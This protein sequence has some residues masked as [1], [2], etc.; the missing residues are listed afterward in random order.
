MAR[1]ILSG[2]HWLMFGDIVA[3]E[4]P[5][6]TDSRAERRS[7]PAQLEEAEAE[8]GACA[9]CATPQFGSAQIELPTMVQ[10][11]VTA[12]PTTGARANL[13]TFA[14]P[15]RG[16]RLTRR[17]HQLSTMDT[18]AGS[19]T[20]LRSHPTSAPTPSSNSTKETS[21]DSGRTV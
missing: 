4:E 7:M 10:R 18:A 9:C 3:T 19:Q 15:H 8:H 20:E 6:T 5:S 1:R 14:T 16:R 11:N 21:S 13:S 17:R 12:P 2:A